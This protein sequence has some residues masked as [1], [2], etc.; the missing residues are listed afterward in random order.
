M[1]SMFDQNNIED[2]EDKYAEIMEI[3]GD[4]DRAQPNG[5]LSKTETTGNPEEIPA[6]F[7]DRE[8]H[9]SYLRHNVNKTDNL[10][11]T[12]TRH[13][14]REWPNAKQPTTKM[15][16]KVKRSI[17]AVPEINVP[18]DNTYSDH[19]NH[20]NPGDK[21]L[22]QATTAPLTIEEFNATIKRMKRKAPGLDGLLVDSFKDLGKKGKQYCSVYITGSTGQES[23]RRTGKKEYYAPYTKR[24][25]QH[26]I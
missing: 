12:P 4:L 26:R 18:V 11:P 23:S 6:P 22:L 24:G 3:I 10:E 19:K 17:S 2:I 1:Q 20:P 25:N 21:L 15:Y 9:T 5:H 14:I 16:S 13:Q 7:Q 8:T